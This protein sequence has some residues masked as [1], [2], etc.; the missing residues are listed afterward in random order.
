MPAIAFGK[1][2]RNYKTGMFKTHMATAPRKI[3]IQHP[4]K[5]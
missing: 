3:R 4:R 1:A 2:D 5:R